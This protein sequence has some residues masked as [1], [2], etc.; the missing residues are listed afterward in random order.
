MALKVLVGSSN[1][2]KIEGVK[3]GFK[4][5]FKNVE[6]KGIRV[7]SG[8]SSQPLTFEETIKGAVLRGWRALNKEEGD[9]G[10]GIEAGLIR[11]PGTITGFMDFQVCAIVDV[12]EEVT[13]GV[14]PGFEFPPRAVKE[15]IEDKAKELGESMARI[16]G[17]I[18]IGKNIGAIGWL[19]KNKMLR[20]E[21]TSIAVIM[22][23]IPRLNRELYG[24]SFRKIRELLSEIF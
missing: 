7:K 16:T 22:A 21:L 19:S 20:D 2:S 9:Y 12:N 23:L 18:D 3:M 8:V 17:I 5:F 4:R 13:L 10:V 24:G 14:G 11:F 15:V 6:I 1:P